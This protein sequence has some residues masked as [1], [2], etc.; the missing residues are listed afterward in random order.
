M[1]TET[2]I[3]N[4]IQQNYKTVDTEYK[5]IQ[6]ILTKPKCIIIVMN[7]KFLLPD[8]SHYLNAGLLL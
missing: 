3:D 2:N 1:R 7:T 5:Y 8:A 6:S 4:K